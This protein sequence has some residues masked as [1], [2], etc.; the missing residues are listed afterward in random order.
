MSLVSIPSDCQHQTW[1]EAANDRS[2]HVTSQTPNPLAPPILFISWI[3]ISIWS[4]KALGHYSHHTYFSLRPIIPPTSAREK[5]VWPARLF[6]SLPPSL[7][8][9]LCCGTFTNSTSKLEAYMGGILSEFNLFPMINHEVSM[10]KG[11][12]GRG[13]GGEGRGGEGER[14]ASVVS[15]SAG[16]RQ[17][18]D[19]QGAYLTPTAHPLTPHTSP[20]HPLTLSHPH[21]LTPCHPLT[22]S[23][24][25]PLTP[26]Q[27]HP[28]TPSL[29]LSY[30]HP[31]TLSHSHT[32]ALSH[33]HPLMP[34]HHHLPTPALPALSLHL[35]PL[36]HSLPPPSPQVNLALE[37]DCDWRVPLL[38]QPSG[39]S[40]LPH[41]HSRQRRGG[42]GGCHGSTL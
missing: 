2:C 5:F 18:H 17:V 14:G 12:E 33:P 30:L 9:V 31:P 16:L 22:H 36:H 7:P 26:S 8:P 39:E 40:L 34:S 42:V 41:S 1:A 27:R 28:L 15:L 32:L 4:L 21:S 19:A 38:S 24:R 10:R 6:H 37:S 20:P 13:G 11:G 29:T 23:P 3:A 25:H 35:S